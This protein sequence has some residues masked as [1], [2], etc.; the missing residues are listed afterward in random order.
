[1]S[2]S[3]SRRRVDRCDA[4][5]PRAVAV[6]GY[7]NPSFT[8]RGGNPGGGQN[9]NR[10]SDCPLR[11][12]ISTP[13]RWAWG[14]SPRLVGEK[15]CL[16]EDPRLMALRDGYPTKFLQYGHGSNPLWHPNCNDVAVRFSY[17]GSDAT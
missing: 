2:R 15:P 6:D 5:P 17:S 3:L 11:S 9:A 8:L 7:H 4:R 12:S 14:I 10:G 1:M 16:Y 13:S